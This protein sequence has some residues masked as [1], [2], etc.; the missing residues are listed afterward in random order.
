MPSTRNACNGCGGYLHFAVNKLRRPDPQEPTRL[1]IDRP[2]DP[3]VNIFL[4][5]STPTRIDPAETNLFMG[6]CQ[7]HHAH[8]GAHLPGCP[9][10]AE[11]IMN[12]IFRLFPDVERPKYADETEEAKLEKMLKAVLEMEGRRL[13]P[14]PPAPCAV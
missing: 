14:E 8:L 7:Q 4:G 3:K 11:V 10:H 6:I 13:E 9:P 2:F 12:A 1:L 5:P